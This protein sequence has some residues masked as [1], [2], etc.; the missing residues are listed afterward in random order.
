MKTKDYKL[1][2][3]DAETI[4]MMCIRFCEGRGSWLL[5]QEMGLST[6]EEIRRY[7]ELAV[8]KLRKLIDLYGSDDDRAHLKKVDDLKRGE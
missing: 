2:D 5:N 3:L 7:K 1:S 8:E 6:I 4:A